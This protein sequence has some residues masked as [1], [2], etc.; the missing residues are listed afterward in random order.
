MPAENVLIYAKSNFIGMCDKIDLWGL[1]TLFDPY[2]V[3]A[4][5]GDGSYGFDK[6]PRISNCDSEI[7][8]YFESKYE[9]KEDRPPRLTKDGKLYKE[10]RVKGIC[11]KLRSIGIYGQTKTKK[12]LP[13]N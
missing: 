1:D 4:L 7:L 10:L 11:Q 6:T 3:G 8:N 9:C 13:D 2:A 5:I 12:R